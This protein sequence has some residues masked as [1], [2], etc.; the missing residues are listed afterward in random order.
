MA[1]KTTFHLPVRP[2]RRRMAGS[3]VYMAEKEN[4]SSTYQTYTRPLGGA[5]MSI[6]VYKVGVAGLDVYK[7]EKKLFIYLSDI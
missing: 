7:A 1:S 5:P 3:D 4:F 6:I 2:F